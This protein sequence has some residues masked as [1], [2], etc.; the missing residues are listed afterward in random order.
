VAYKYQLRLVALAKQMLGES[1]ALW[2]A[3]SMKQRLRL[4]GILYLNPPLPKG[5]AQ[6]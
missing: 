4:L 5:T 1:A 6:L 3:L 2:L